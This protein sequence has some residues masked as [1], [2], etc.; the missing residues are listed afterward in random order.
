VQCFRWEA[1]ERAS[2]APL[3]SEQSKPFVDVSQ[4]FAAKCPQ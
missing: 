4:L 3:N 1:Q 2:S